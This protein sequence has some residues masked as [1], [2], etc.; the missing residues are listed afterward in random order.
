[1][2]FIGSDMFH[3]TRN[4]VVDVLRSSHEWPQ[5]WF[6]FINWPKLHF[7]T[8]ARFR[9][10]K[11]CSYLKFCNAQFN[12]FTMHMF[13]NAHVL[14]CTVVKHLRVHLLCTINVYIPTYSFFLTCCY[15]WFGIYKMLFMQEIMQFYLPFS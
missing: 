7:H 5:Q 3:N 8:S 10:H 12:H 2:R 14:Q 15:N 1:M 4:H 9:R 11:S 13:Y 6:L